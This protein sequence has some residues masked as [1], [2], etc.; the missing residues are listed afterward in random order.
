MLKRNAIS[1]AMEDK[2]FMGVIYVVLII[3]FAVILMP[4]LHILSASISDPDEVMRGQ[5]TFYP[6]HI[7]FI[8]YNTIFESKEL[9]RG[10][11]NSVFY[12]SAGTLIQVIT[13]LL[14]S[15]PLSR[16]HFYGKNIITAIVLITMFFSGGLIPTYLVV[17]SLGLLDTRWAMIL[18]GAMAGFQVLVARTFFQTAIPE[19]LVEAAELDGASQITIFARIVLPLSTPIIAVLVVIYAVGNW[20]SF[21]DALIYLNSTYLFPLQIIL[22]NILVLNKPQTG[23]DAVRMMQLL[24]ISALLKYALIVVSSVPILLFYPL[25]QKYFVKGLTIGSLKG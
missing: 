14:I 12:T 15:Y 20:N 4:L 11:F 24:R 13:T 21:F 25:I 8:A 22:R 3:L 7:S 10:F 19:E 2:I 17:K 5:V 6:R 9:V 1:G 18:P 16:R 23:Y